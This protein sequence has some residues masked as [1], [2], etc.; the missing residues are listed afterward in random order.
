MGLP[1]ADTAYNA[2]YDAFGMNTD[3]TFGSDI[4][5]AV[6][7][8]YDSSTDKGQLFFNI[9]GHD[10]TV[11]FASLN[12]AAI[13][14]LGMHEPDGT[15]DDVVTGLDVAGTI[16]GVDAKGSGQYLT[17]LDGNVAASN[18]FYVSNQQSAILTPPLTIDATN[19]TFTIEL[20]GFEAVITVEQGVYVTGAA[21]AEKVQTAI[22][23]NAAIDAEDL[24]VKVD[25]T[26]DVASSAFGTIGI[27]STS[28]GTGSSVLMKDVSNEAS[29]AY[30]FVVG[31]G[32][33][34]VGKNKD[35][36]VDDASGIRVKVTGGALGDRGSVTYISGIADQ[37]KDLLQEFL[38]PKNGILA[39]K[40]STLDTQND[41]LAEDRESF[42]ARV[43][44]TEARLKAQFLYNDAIISTLKV[45]E[46]FLTQQFEAMANANK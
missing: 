40:F 20:D 8:E 26:D 7:Y 17:A 46:N 25:Y 11:A 31:Q 33:G 39:T 2:G 24:S 9:G 5:A 45:T 28:T 21:L 34:E 27:I 30:G 14:W 19:D 43:A 41:S 29:T 35:G 37:L 23:D 13:S 32:E 6:R 15:E 1:V 36:N 38:D 4:T 42:D 44:A 16:N 18:G 22:N 12:A 10:N 3:I